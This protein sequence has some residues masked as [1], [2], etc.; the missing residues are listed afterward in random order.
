MKRIDFKRNLKDL[1]EEYPEIVGI[2]QRLGFTE[3]VKPGMLNTVGRVMTIPK[4]AML[5]GFD[6]EKIKNEFIK[7]GFEIIE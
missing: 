6:I 5:R 2:M 3:I 7:N 4:G 1:V